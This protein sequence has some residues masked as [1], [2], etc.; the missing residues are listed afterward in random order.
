MRKVGEEVEVVKEE[1]IEDE[2]AKQL[3]LTRA[4]LELPHPEEK[5]LKIK[6]KQNKKG[7]K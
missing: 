2:V 3:R 7:A 4:Q 6:N 5:I 1:E